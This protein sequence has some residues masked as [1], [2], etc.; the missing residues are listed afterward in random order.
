MCGRFAFFQEIEPLVDDLDAV[1]LT[2]GAL[3]ARF[4]IPPTT[5]I[6]VVTESVDRDSGEVIR[7][8]RVARWGLLPRFAADASFSS[9]TFNARRE[10]LESKA[11]FKGS[12]A[13]Y[14]A[15]VPMDGYF[16]W[17]RVGEGRTRIPHFVRHSHSEALFAAGLVS[18]WKGPGHHD[19]AAASDT[20]S[21][22][23]TATVITRAAHGHMAELHDRVPVFLDR[24][25]ID[26]WLSP[27]AFGPG[28][29]AHGWIN[30]DEHVLPLSM[31]S[32]HEVDRSVGNVRNDSPELVDPIPGKRVH[33]AERL[34][35]VPWPDLS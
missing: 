7:A 12:L 13:S 5:P 35:V 33:T 2:Q 23:L 27:Q 25:G 32:F 6:H 20:G 19:S 3:H 29:E 11:S 34:A 31:L 21:W 15:V 16:E 1:D 24:N 17:K 30:D 4:N 10:T 8:L 14:R 9:R 26:I 28:Q 22:L 18:W